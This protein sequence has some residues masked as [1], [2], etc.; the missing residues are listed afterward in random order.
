MGR[1]G[2]VGKKEIS[3]SYALANSSKEAEARFAA[4]SAIYDRGT[5]RHLGDLGVGQGWRCLEVGGGSGTIAKWLADRVAPTGHVLTTDLDTRFLDALRGQSLEVRCHNIGVDPLPEAVFDLI[6]ARLV[7]M[8]V[9]QRK[10]ALARMI[11][12]LKRGGWLFLEEYDSCSMLPDPIVN[13]AEA[14]LQTQLAMLQLLEDRGVDRRY[15]RLLPGLLRA[16]GL[17]RVE[18]EAQLFL[19]QKE[20]QGTN[21]MRANFEQ[22]R[23]EMI[24]GHYITE[25]QFDRDMARLDD[26][27]F[28][29][30]S[31]ILWSVWGQRS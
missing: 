24:H 30:P 27:N 4:L 3:A 12:S 5:V 21:L 29:M 26:P 20:S 15:G 8:H 17:S 16:R 1:V 10:E 9:P 18:A 25:Q 7:L 2:T 28:L 22:L 14:L 6:H 31:S 19:W 11:S 13:S 23:E